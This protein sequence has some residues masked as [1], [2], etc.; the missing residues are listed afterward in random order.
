MPIICRLIEL[1]V[2]VANGLGDRASVDDAVKNAKIF[3]G[4]YRY[5]HG[6][7]FLL[8]RHSPDTA[9]AHLLDIG[10]AVT[11]ADD[12]VPASRLLSPDDTQRLNDAI[13]GTEPDA[14]APH[15]DAEAMDAAGVYPK[16]WVEWE[17]T[18][19]PLGQML[20]NYWFLVQFVRRCAHAGDALLLYYL[21]ERDETDE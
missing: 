21:F 9:A 5:W 7:A 20:E 14:L 1:P 6:I 13:T 10:R 16:T 18:F 15:Y 8:A 11:P 17:E 2:A 19:D 4:M 12:A 3:S